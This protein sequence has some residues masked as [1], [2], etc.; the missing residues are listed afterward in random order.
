[1]VTPKHGVKV[2]VCESLRVWP[3]LLKGIHGY[4]VTQNEDQKSQ[5]NP[6]MCNLGKCCIHGFI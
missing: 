5:A 6:D 3:A 4:L 2:T 1:M